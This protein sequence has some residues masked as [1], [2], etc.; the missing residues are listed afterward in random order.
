[1][2]SRGKTTRYRL[3]PDRCLGCGYVCD[4]AA[5]VDGDDM[6]NSGDITICIECGHIMAFGLDLRLRA[7]TDAEMHTVAGDRRIIVAQRAIAELRR[8]KHG[9]GR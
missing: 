5:A 1:M 8:R 4:A 3:K 2:T 7:L 9:N 6:P